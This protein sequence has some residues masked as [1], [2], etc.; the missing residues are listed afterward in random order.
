M[1][2]KNRVSYMRYSSDNQ[3]EHSI[4]YQRAAIESY[5]KRNGLTILNEYIDEGFSATTDKRPA[6]QKMIEDSKNHPNWDMILV[7]DLN[8][9]FRNIRDSITYKQELLDRGIRIVSVTE[10]F[11]ES[12]EGDLLAAIVDAMNA[13]Y[14]KDN[15]KRT[16]AGLS[17]NAKNATHCGG[18]P[19]LGYDVG[20][21]GK[22]VINEAE[23][24]IVREIF[25]LYKLGY[26]YKK[27][28]D[29]LNEKGVTTKAGK[30]FTK[31][32]FYNI[33]TQEKYIGTYRWNLRTAKKSKGQR[34]NHAY[35]P[36]EE[37][38]I[39]KDGCPVIIFPSCTRQAKRTCKRP[40]RCQEP[41]FLHA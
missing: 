15:A 30:P 41:L 1:S 34:N 39:I 22:L 20:T 9:A 33:L 18:V 5:C 17:V 19:P 3:S 31:N 29:Y 7:F 40:F 13:Q 2:N 25:S 36:L 23:A 38:T 8:R 4:E 14:S 12:S 28:A 11:T 37:Q 24:A 10:S 21:N 6:F 16:F 27:M 32:S 35:K 26:S